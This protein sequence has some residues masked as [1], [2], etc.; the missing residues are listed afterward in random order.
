[1]TSGVQLYT[2]DLAKHVPM[3]EVTFFELWDYWIHLYAVKKFRTQPLWLE[4]PGRD[5]R[6]GRDGREPSEVPLDV[7]TIRK[8]LLVGTLLMIVNLQLA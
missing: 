3:C 7:K 4:R 8:W 6:D 2:S 5:G 1:M